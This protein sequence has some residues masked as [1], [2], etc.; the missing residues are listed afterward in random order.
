MEVGDKR[1]YIEVGGI[2]YTTTIDTLRR[3]PTLDAILLDEPSE[4]PVFIDRDGFAFQYVLNFL[5]NGSVY[6]NPEDRV[7]IEFLMGEAAYFGLK[8]MESQL[9]KLLDKK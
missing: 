6:I 9:T 3:S 8:K 2:I 7:Y 4:I 5:R 1:Y